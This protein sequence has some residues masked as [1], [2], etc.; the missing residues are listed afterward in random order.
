MLNQI[1]CNLCLLVLILVSGEGRT[2]LGQFL[3]ESQ[4]ITKDSYHAFSP[5]LLILGFFK[6]LSSTGSSPLWQFSKMC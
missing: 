6:N 1:S 2:S 5:G 3:C 4:L